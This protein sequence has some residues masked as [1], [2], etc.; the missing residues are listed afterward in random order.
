MCFIA[1]FVFGLP[2]MA[3]V[4]ADDTLPTLPAGTNVYSRVRVLN[5]T[6]TDVYFTFNN[7][8]G[9]GLA[10]VKLS[11][12]SPALQKYFHYNAAQAATAEQREIQANAEYDQQIARA[13]VVSPPDETRLPA[14]IVHASD[15]V[16]GTDF[17]HA[18][19]QAGAEKKLV[20]LYFTG[21]D[22]CPT[23][24]MYGRTVLSTDEFAT[25][26]QEHLELVL[27][28]FPHYKPQSDTLKQNNRAVEEQ[29]GV[30]EFPTTMVM[31]SDGRE[32]KRWVGIPDGGLQ[33]IMAELKKIQSLVA[34]N[35]H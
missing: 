9:E 29:F 10:N 13:P 33:T 8:K 34:A 27:L 5:V 6:A 15:L 2:G 3:G 11:R 28:D 7:G 21:S 20:F 31:D 25:F 22:W 17:P 32:L 18:L 16:W 23:C 26:A 12:L 19:H 4:L 14:R 24:K 35:A 1:V 30:T